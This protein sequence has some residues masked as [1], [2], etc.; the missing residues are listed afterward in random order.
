MADIRGITI[1]INGNTTKLDRALKDVNRSARETDKSLKQIQNSLKFNPGNTEL[2]AQK[3]R[4]LS[5]AIEVTSEKLA[6]L[7][8]AQEQAKAALEA[9]NLG[10]DKYDALTREILKTENQLER[11]KSQLEQ[12]SP[13]ELQ[14]A[15]ASEQRRQKLQELQK[16]QEQ[17]Q[18]SAQKLSQQYELQVASL[19][20]NASAADKL[21]ARQEYLKQAIQNTEQQVQTLEQALEVAKAEYG[22]NST[23]VNHLEQQ[24]L[25]TKLAAQEFAN[26]WANV[27]NSLKNFSDNALRAGEN[28]TDVGK[29]LTQK[30]TVPLTALGGLA[31][32]SASDYEGAMIGVA[33]TTDMSTKELETMG[34]ELRRISK[35]EIPMSVTG[36]AEIAESAGQLGIKKE[37]IVEFTKTIANMSEATNMTA[38]QAASDMAKFANITNMPQENFE[39]LGSAIV[40]VG[41]NFATTESDIMAMAMRLAGAGSQVGMSEAQI[42][43]LA[44][45]LSSVGIEAEAGGSA[46]SKVMVDMQLAVETGGDKLK[47][48]ADVAGMSS[49]EF[50]SAFK[51][52]AGDAITAFITGLGNMEGKG[53]SAIKTLDDMGLTEVRLRDALLRSSSSAG[54]FSDAMQTATSAWDENTALANEADKRYESFASKVQLVRNKLNDLGIVIG[55]KLLPYVSD[56]LDFI[57]KLIDGFGKLPEDV[58][59]GIVLFGAIAAAI[60]PILLVL[61]GFA[62]VIGT[63]TGALAVVTGGATA[64]TPAIAG[65]ATMFKVLPAILNVVKLAIGALTSPIGLAI[66]AVV[67]LTILIVT[68][69][70]QIKEK[71]IEIWGA[72]K[73]FF[74]N[75]WEGV[76]EK[77]TETWESITT[78]LTE[79]WNAFIETVKPIWDTL[80]NVFTVVWLLIQEIFRTAWELVSVPLVA[81]WNLLVDTAKTIFQALADFFKIIWDAIKSTAEAAWNAIKSALETVWN[82]IKSVATTAFNAI[83]DVVK[84]AWNAIQTAT[85]PV[86]NAIKGVLESI[87]NAIKNVAESVFNAI[88]D[89][90]EKAWNAIKSI[91]ESVWN[92]IKGTLDGIWNGIKG[93]AISIFNSV[94][95]EISG[96]WNGIKGITTDAWESIKNT[97]SNAIDTA[98]DAVSNA[99]DRIKDILSVTLPFPDI[100]LPHFS[101][102][103][104]FSLDPPSVPDFSVS[105]YDKGGIFD[106]PTVIGVGE[107]RPEFVGALEDL[108]FLISDELDKRQRFTGSQVIVK[109]N[110]FTI[111]EEADIK[112]IAQELYNLQVKESRKRGIVG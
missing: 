7:K 90:I 85:A 34:N 44:G 21:K 30:V 16:S 5:K 95:N 29:S 46:F 40:E 81:A 54:L 73:D 76:Q 6:T 12:I 56:M 33:K 66:A 112:K 97:I 18:Q 80:V 41:N 35:E 107:K 60:G 8:A 79:T 58:Q 109:D 49:E 64:A 104:G 4:E 27:G 74:G 31:V 93:T 106:R 101:I 52:N 61:G 25:E 69:W 50:A 45:A 48:Y 39:R 103:G 67:A 102:S 91:G 72:I 22:E 83:K 42:V 84:K 99:I 32:K 63:V 70:D 88:K 108:R 20:N 47:Q 36:L 11:Y 59:K 89:V 87:W 98:R 2:I 105:W 13:A 68:H 14:A 75:I 43:G 28:L 38:E 26:E 78:W 62:K 53:Q 3:H 55:E 17:L 100:P 92:G 51:N 37:N 71:T 86:W 57:G 23:E 15:Q 111:R 94:K 77:W 10:Q 65:L 19:G 24:L 82:A 1:E 96:I 110:H 9:G